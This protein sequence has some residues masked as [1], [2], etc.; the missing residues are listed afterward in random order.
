MSAGFDAMLIEMMILED[1]Q[2]TVSLH[3]GDLVD[4]VAGD[5]IPDDNDL[6]NVDMDDLDEAL[7]D[8]DEEGDE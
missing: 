4:I 6:P 8:D 5:E 2:E 3:D 7:G 1:D